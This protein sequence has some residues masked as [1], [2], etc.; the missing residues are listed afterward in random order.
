MLSSCFVAVTETNR[1]GDS[2]SQ[3]G[4]NVTSGTLP[5][6]S[7]P[8]GNPPFPGYTTDNGVNWIGEIVE[9]APGCTLNFN[10]AYGGATVNA[11]LVTPFEPTVLSFIDQVT[12]FTNSVGPKPK[13]YKWTSA[14]TAAA[15]WLGVNDVGNSYYYANSSAINEADLNSYFGQLQILYNAGVRK[16]LLLTTPRKA[17]VSL[18]KT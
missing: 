11:S 1:S 13:G 10:F 5:S 15:V 6:C 4:F 8:M 3:T 18:C 16:F 14:N 12:E 7:N 9:T 17:S 2:Y